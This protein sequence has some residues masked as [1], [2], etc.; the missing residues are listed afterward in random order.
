MKLLKMILAII[1]TVAVLLI[2][3]FLFGRYSWKLFGFSVCETAG[4]QR[5][6][7]LNKNAKRALI[8]VLL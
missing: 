8:Q 4:I 5:H 2:A 6:F 3:V 1:L 7:K